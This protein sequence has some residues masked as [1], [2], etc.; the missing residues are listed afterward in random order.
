MLASPLVWL[1][2][3][4]AAVGTV[5][6]VK[7]ESD[8]Q[9]KTA[10]AQAWL[11]TPAGQQFALQAMRA[12]TTTTAGEPMYFAPEVFLGSGIARHPFTSTGDL[13]D[14]LIDL[15]NA[16]AM[17]GKMDDL[18]ARGCK[19]YQYF[20]GKYDVGTSQRTSA[21]NFFKMLRVLVYPYTQSATTR[22]QKR[23]VFHENHAKLAELV[24]MW[25]QNTHADAAGSPITGSISTGGIYTF[26]AREVGTTIPVG[27]DFIVTP[28]SVAL[29]HVSS[30]KTRLMGDP[31]ETQVVSLP[32]I[33]NVSTSG[34]PPVL[35]ANPQV[36]NAFR[37]MRPGMQK[38]MLEWNGPSGYGSEESD[39]TVIAVDQPVQT[40]GAA[41]QGPQVG[42]FETDSDVHALCGSIHEQALALDRA[43][44]S[45]AAQKY[46]PEVFAT[47]LSAIPSDKAASFA[48]DRAFY[49]LWRE[50]FMNPW[51]AH[52]QRLAALYADS[53]FLVN[54][55]DEYRKLRR[56]L[57][58]LT[59]WREGI[60]QRVPVVAYS[61]PRVGDDFDG[62]GPAEVVKFL[63]SIHNAA[64]AFERALASNATRK[65][66]PR[67]FA[68]S[69]SEIDPASQAKFQAQRDFY[70]KWRERFMTPWLEDRESLRH[71]YTGHTHGFL[72]SY[73]RD[74]EK[75]KVFEKALAEWRS[76]I[77]AT[78]PTTVVGYA[79]S[80]DEGVPLFDDARARNLSL[81]GGP[82]SVPVGTSV[83]ILP[84]AGHE[85]KTVS[86]ANAEGDVLRTY[87]DGPTGQFVAARPGTQVVPCTFTVP[88]EGMSYQAS[89]QITA[90]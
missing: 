20:A 87:D 86:A 46:G 18:Y 66:G 48:A 79:P 52:Y 42:L 26:S 35:A 81:G 80:A 70:Q 54:S 58:V 8:R 83:R 73:S 34:M 55:A 30:F 5:L 24:T 72:H 50:R 33:E 69:I 11:Q 41:Y 7:S 9:K 62:I 27:S 37:A 45:S 19:A 40:S 2:G 10:A 88:G 22:D 49:R 39:V 82:Y 56:Y 75:L 25:E 61:G 44:L 3:A 76:G 65:Y 28:S 23:S 64:L 15:V 68:A 47:G 43:L 29:D 4:G 74:Y 78:V 51:T 77:E 1:L 14:S 16:R 6:V 89:V 36:P 31:V 85:L 63:N 17:D 38:V 32:Q 59:D 53:M 67:G 13:G 90:A 57:D 71:R 84:P 21:E 60:Q 12:G